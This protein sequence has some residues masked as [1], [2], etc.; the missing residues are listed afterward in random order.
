MAIWKAYVLFATLLLLVGTGNGQGR[1]ELEATT[2]T[3]PDQ[4]YGNEEMSE[5]HE[6]KVGNK[7]EPIIFEPNIKLS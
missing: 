2:R 5:E 7:I 6:I 3:C 4:L 1:Y